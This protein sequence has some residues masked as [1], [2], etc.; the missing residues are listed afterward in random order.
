[1]KTKNYLLLFITVLLILVACKKDKPV[2]RVVEFTSTTYVSLGT[3]NSV[4]KPD[5][6]LTPDTIS[7]ALLAY[8]NATLPEGQ[9]LRNTH[10][11]LLS[12][13]A[14]ADVAITQQSDV[15]ITFVSHTGGYTNTF[16]FY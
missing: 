11:E 8:I 1:M 2:T 9:D 12:T 14:T 6:L 5:Y 4:G 3:Y 10:P 15:F 16:A 13:E 7:P